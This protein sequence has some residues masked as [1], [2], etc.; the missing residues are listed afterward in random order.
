MLIHLDVFGDVQLSRE[1]LRWRHAAD[2]MRPALRDV[3]D[4]FFAVAGRQFKT[5]GGFASGGWAPLTPTYQA[6]KAQHFPG[7]GILE[8]TGVMLRSLTEEGAEG[9]VVVIEP[10]RLVWGTAVEYAPF[11]QLGTRKMAQRRPVELRN[12]DRNK[13]P[14]ILQNF[15]ATGRTG[16]IRL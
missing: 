16:V 4:Y 1:L 9:N 6:W 11:H 15:L 3:A 12:Q 10:D 8:R 7:R 14:K 13:V 2:D 5:E